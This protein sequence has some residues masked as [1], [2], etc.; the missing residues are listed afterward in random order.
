MKVLD[1]MIKVVMIPFLI[2]GNKCDLNDHFSSSYSMD[3]SM[4]AQRLNLTYFEV[5]AKLYFNVNKPWIEW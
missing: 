5:S 2:L 4:M 1:D 3:L